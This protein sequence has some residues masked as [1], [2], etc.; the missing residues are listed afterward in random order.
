MSELKTLKDL[1]EAENNSKKSFRDLGYLDA[2][3][4]LKQEAIKWAK[5]CTY[6]ANQKF[7]DDLDIRFWTAKRVGLMEFFNITEE[8]LEDE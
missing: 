4:D 8:D 5:E 2:L 7:S 6:K 1:E 3:K